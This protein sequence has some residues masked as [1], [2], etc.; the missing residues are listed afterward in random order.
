MYLFMIKFISEIILPVFITIY[1]ITSDIQHLK[2]FFNS[3]ETLEPNDATLIFLHGFLFWIIFPSLLLYNTLT[4]F[5]F[6]G[7]LEPGTPAWQIKLFG[8]TL[9]WILLITILI[10][11]FIV[12]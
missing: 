12:L 8:N 4:Y 2:I 7:K 11:S 9:S 3:S 6:D 5:D 1:F 10:K